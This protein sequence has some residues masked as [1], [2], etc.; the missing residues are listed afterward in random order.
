MGD[1]CCGWHKNVVRLD[2]DEAIEEAV[3]FSKIAYFLVKNK[4]EMF[5]AYEINSFVNLTY[6][7]LK[8]NFI[9]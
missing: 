7:K 1:K 4:I 8:I 2:D 9:S 3:S 6:I 5:N